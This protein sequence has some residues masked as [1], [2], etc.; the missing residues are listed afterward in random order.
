[1]G[2]VSGGFKDQ[3]AR[4]RARAA[5]P[6]FFIF[7]FFK[8]YKTNTVQFSFTP[9]HA[10]NF[11]LRLSRVLSLAALNHSLP[12]RRRSISL[13]PT[14]LN[15]SPLN[16]SLSHTAQSQFANLILGKQ[17]Q[18]LF[19]VFVSKIYNLSLMG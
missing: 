2:M 6:I 18:T 12:C 13:S 5:P 7:Y 15:L 8:V 19:Y 4:A 14:P 10:S 9:V 11:F 1:M 16:L 17:T 3:H